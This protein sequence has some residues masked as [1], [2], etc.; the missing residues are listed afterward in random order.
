MTN[1]FKAKE[2]AEKTI[3]DAAT[4]FLG[5]INEMSVDFCKWSAE[6][7]AKWKD[8]QFKEYLEKKKAEYVSSRDDADMWS[9]QWA[10]YHA[11]ACTTHQIINELFGEE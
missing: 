4:S 7:M 2:I 8:K 11:L 10:V 6:E 1:E 3:G 9:E 5:W